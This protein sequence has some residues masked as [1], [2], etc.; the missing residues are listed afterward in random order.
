MMD[1]AFQAALQRY[2]HGNGSS[3]AIAAAAVAA[4]RAAPSLVQRVYFHRIGSPFQED[5]IDIPI[6]DDPERHVASALI[7]RV[8][9]EPA[10]NAE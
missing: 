4:L 6:G 10:E 7:H 8:L 5:H 2:A 3:R 9:V 1:G